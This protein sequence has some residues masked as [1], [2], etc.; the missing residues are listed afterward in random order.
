VAVAEEQFKQVLARWVTGVTIVTARDG[1]RIHGMTVSAFTEVS[2]DPPL[3]LVC[4]DKQSNT[5]PVIAAGKVFAVNILAEDQ[6]ALSNKF[7]SKKHEAERFDDL[8]Y[9]TGET[10]APLLSHCVANLD[11][12]VVAAHDHGDHI[13][14]VGE[15]VGLRQTSAEPLL[16]HAGAY[17]VFSKIVG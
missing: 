14:Y 6:W 7:A 4:A 12:R 1:D 15:V 3:V 8:V 13:V 9:E 11:C 5:N 16:Y 17:G 10:G 2:L